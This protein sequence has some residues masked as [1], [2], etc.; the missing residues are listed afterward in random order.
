MGGGDG[1]LNRSPKN[2]G[3]SLNDFGK[4]LGPGGICNTARDGTRKS[5]AKCD[6]LTPRDIANRFGAESSTAG[7]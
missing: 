7:M 4:I 3:R 6:T 2:D 1:S 5:Y